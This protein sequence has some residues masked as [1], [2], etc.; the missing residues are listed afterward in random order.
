[1]KEPDSLSVNT[2]P[3]AAFVRWLVRY[4]FPIAILNILLLIAIAF[5]AGQLSLSSGIR[6]LFSDDDPNLMAEIAIENAY[7][8]EDN[9]LLV[10]D[11]GDQ[12]MFTQKNLQTLSTITE[13]SWQV[14]HSRR[15]DSVVNFLHTTVEEDD[16][17]INALVEDVAV[18]SP[19]ELEQK[20]SIALSEQLLVG[21]LISANGHVAAVNITLNVNEDGKAA[22]LADAVNYAREIAAQAH[23][24]NPQVTV[25][26]AGLALTEQTLAEVTAA[27]GATLIPLLFVM[28][29]VVLAVLL[30]SPLAALC[31]VITIVLSVAAGMGFGGWSGYSINSVNVSAPTIIMTLAVAD[32]IHFLSSFLRRY[33]TGVESSSAVEKRVAIEQALSQTLYPIILTSVTTAIGFLSMNFS[34]SPPFGELGTLSAVG[35]VAALW[36][37]MTILPALVL[38]L[39]FKP[40]QREK[41]SWSLLPLA[42]WVIA[43]HTAIFWVSLLLIATIISFI[44]RMELNDDPAGYFSEDI[45]L[46]AA[47]STVEEKFSGTQNIHYSLN[48]GQEGGVSDPQFLAD[49]SRFVDWLR[50]QPEVTNVD[51]FID[52]MK[53]LNQVMHADDP[54]WHRL[55]DTRELAAQY[56]LL[57]EISVPYGQDVTH[58]ITADKSALKVTAVLKNQKSRVVDFERRSRAWLEQNA[59]HLETRGAGHAVSFAS[60]GLRNINNMLVGSL[61][62]IVLVSG[63]LLLAFRSLRFGMLSFIPN[64][65]PALISLG[66]WS[67][68][69]HEVNMAASVVFSMTL[70]IVVDDTTH[71]LVKYR[72]ARISQGLSASDAVRDTFASVGRALL[73]T[74]V[75]LAAGFLVLVQSDFSV[76]AT[77][78]FL[79][80]LTIVVAIVLDLL[81]L[82]ALLIK[83][84]RWLVK[85][86]AS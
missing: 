7:G 24:A 59:P 44:P 1:M 14:P 40:Q 63:C 25:Q 70:G 12:S 77:S 43:K 85:P 65:F 55:P 54:L 2:G 58:Q 81:F 82:P 23:S 39:P 11:A 42:D 4:A 73:I 78:G 5:G 16:I 32:C 50:E 84:D 8:R 71:F 69:F 26:L 68:L 13:Q 64:L 46:T 60:I 37:T 74:S 41:Q 31:T 61:F 33:S 19:Q 22:A 83:A 21:R 49:V 3:Y 67:A 6:V 53:R 38:L 75:V 51:S 9:I 10:L 48:S 57:Y 66:V 30:R 18:L 34:D 72:Q 20:K 62:A 80:S 29:L 79:M 36:V 35:V 56:L 27:D 52:T 28:V 76:N 47:I 86:A 15:V 45:A 17:F